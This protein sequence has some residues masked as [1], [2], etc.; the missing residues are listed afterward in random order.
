MTTNSTSAVR[1]LPRIGLLILLCMAA[2]L[3]YT[4]RDALDAKGIMQAVQSAGVFAPLAFMAIYAAATVAFVPG[5]VLTLAGGALFG[6]L[7]GTF[8]S[9]TGATIG[10]TLAFLAGRHLGLDRLRARLGGRAAQIIEGVER[11][12]WRFV[13][14]VRL[15]PLVPFNLLNYALGLTRIRLIRYVVTSYVAM[16]P[17]AFAY[18]YLGYAGREAAAGN[19]GLIQKGLLALALLAAVALLPRLIQRIRKTKAPEPDKL[20][21]AELKER[22]DQ[23]P[24]D[25]AV[26]DVRS[27]K[28][29]AGSGGHIPNARNIPLAELSARLGELSCYRNRPLAV[30]CNTN[31]MSGQAVVLL[32][33]AGF[34][35]VIL[36]EDGMAGWNRQGFVTE[37]T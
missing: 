2:L 28:D 22:L 24:D 27:L 10:A 25:I 16:L 11:E 34:R 19:S 4:H 20:L 3:A 23:G 6:P 17:G 37:N 5:S 31:R 18:T 1:Y 29:Y 33:D 7:A 21:A 14:L 8:Y 35:Q 36:I 9:L 15:V 13:A 32:R 26:L 30:V 12:D